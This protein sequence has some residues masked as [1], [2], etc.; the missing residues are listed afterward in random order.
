VLL[1]LLSRGEDICAELPAVLDLLASED[2]SRRGVGW[3]ALTSVFPELAVSLS[4]YR[5][6]D[7]VEVCRR[8]TD[9]LRAEAEPGAADVTM[10]VKPRPRDDGTVSTVA[11]HGPARTADALTEP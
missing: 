10:K 7:P 11:D 5:L 1:E 4:D 6:D 3:A 8:K 9:R 2:F